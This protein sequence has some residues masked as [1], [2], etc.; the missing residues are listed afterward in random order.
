M[1]TYQSQLVSPI[2]TN[3]MQKS[4]FLVL[5]VLAVGSHAQLDSC[6]GCLAT[7]TQL[8]SHAT[9]AE[10]IQVTKFIHTKT[11][12]MK[13]IRLELIVKHNMYENKYFLFKCG[14]F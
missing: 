11:R 10:S 8:T 6:E 1:K 2:E 3:K 14:I 13:K 9:S 4:F 12:I 7:L 5:A